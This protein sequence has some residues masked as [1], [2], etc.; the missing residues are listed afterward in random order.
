MSL[1]ETTVTQYNRNM[2]TAVI[3]RRLKNNG[4]NIG[5]AH[6]YRLFTR[7]GISPSGVRQRPQQYPPDTAERILKHFGLA[8][9]GAVPPRSVPNGNGNGVRRPPAWI[10]SLEQI[11]K[12]R[13]AK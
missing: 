1:T 11:K 13:R 9:G 2:T 7:L 10:L 6:L 8:G 3:L 4:K 5:L 12:E